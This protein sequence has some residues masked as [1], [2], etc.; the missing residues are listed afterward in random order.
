[1]TTRFPVSYRWARLMPPLLTLALLLCAAV[2]PLQAQTPPPIVEYYHV[3]ALG[4]VRA[5][6]DHAGAV[7]QRHDYAAF[8]E[9]LPPQIV[10]DD[11]LRFTGKERDE[12][13]SLDYFGARYYASRTG[14][15]TTVDPVLDQQKALLDPQRWNRYAY[16]LNNPLRNVDPDGRDPVPTAWNTGRGAD[17][18]VRVL[19]AV[20]KALWNIVVSLNS[21]G[22]PSG[23]EAEARRDA[24]FMQ[25]ASTEEAIIM[26]LTDVAMLA[27]PLMRGADAGAPGMIDAR[28]VRF[29]QNSIAASFR[30]GGSVDELAAGLRNG[31]IDAKSIPAIRLVERDGKL[32]SLDNRRL[33]AAQRAGVKIPYR[34]ATPEE[35]LKERFKFTT[36]NGGAGVEVR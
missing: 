15:F 11:K 12:T 19:P 18:L 5:V 34:M 23:S 21:P 28:S 2:L 25:P 30:G 7:V 1:M 20:G 16:A 10:R 31:T 33:Y 9:E 29:S 4:T 32:Y 26:G 14:R 8:G 36:T 13:T 22:H 27:A 35:I 24:Q 17:G 3:D 6:T